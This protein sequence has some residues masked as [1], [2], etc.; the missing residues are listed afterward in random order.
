M[1]DVKLESIIERNGLPRDAAHD[2]AFA[3]RVY[4]LRNELSKEVVMKELKT[5]GYS[6]YWDSHNYFNSLSV[7]NRVRI[8]PRIAHAALAKTAFQQHRDLLISGEAVFLHINRVYGLMIPPAETS[9]NPD[10]FFI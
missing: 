10:T 3:C 8:S 5:L 7:Q 6:T 2:L 4:R 9:G 1:V